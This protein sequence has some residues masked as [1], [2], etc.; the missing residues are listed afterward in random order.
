M[1][2]AGIYD[3]DSPHLGGRSKNQTGIGSRFIPGWRK[4]DPGKGREKMKIMELNNAQLEFLAANRLDW[5][6]ANRPYWMADNRP[7]WIAANRPYWMADN[8]PEWMAAN[9]P[10]WMA[11]NRP[12]WMA[13]NRPEWDDV[14]QGIM[15]ALEKAGKK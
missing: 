13:D 3:H 12:E 10:E 4:A 14:P 5:I 15:D 6:A 8:R 11:D 9:R 7:E 1:R 2:E